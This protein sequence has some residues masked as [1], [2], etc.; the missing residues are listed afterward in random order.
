MKKLAIFLFLFAVRLTAVT[1]PA[2]PGVIYNYVD[3]TGANIP[4]RF[5]IDTNRAYNLTFPASVTGAQQNEVLSLSQF[6]NFGYSGVQPIVTVGP[7][8]PPSSLNGFIAADVAENANFAITTAQLGTMF[9]VT[10]AASTI[11]ATLPSAAAAGDGW[12]CFIRKVDTGAGLVVTSPTTTPAAT[13]VAIQDYV[14]LFWTD[15]TNWYTRPWKGTIDAAG[16]IAFK[17]TVGVGAYTTASNVDPG[18]ILYATRTTPPATL[19]VGLLDHHY[20][21]MTPVD[22]TTVQTAGLFDMQ[23]NGA[24]TIGAGHSIGFIARCTD[25]SSNV[26]AQFSGFE[27]KRQ[28]FGTSDNG[29]AI[30]SDTL[31]NMASATGRTAVGVFSTA[32]FFNG[33]PS[34]P[35]L[36]GGFTAFHAQ[37][38]GFGT[39]EGDSTKFFSLVGDANF[40]LQTGGLIASY[41][42]ATPL[43]STVATNYVGMFHNGTDGF[44]TVVGTGS[45]QLGAASTA[46]L[47]QTGDSLDPLTTGGSLGLSTNRWALTATTVA[48]NSSILSS[49]ATAGVGYTTGAGGAVTQLTSR[50]TGVTLNTVSGDITLF[51]AAGSATPATFTVTDSAIGAHDTVEVNEQS[52]TNLYETFV[53]AISAGSFNITFFTTGGTASDAPVFKFNVIKGS[54]N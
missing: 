51:T 49:S 40:K 48:A 54:A 3:T 34:A 9:Q 43:P 37:T 17:P 27:A 14:G 5:G 30:F 44:L 46:V 2:W 19:T 8:F 31:Y 25:T 41:S 29:A 7:L 24:D 22:N 26:S 42:G 35:I 23:L 1:V 11:T 20:Y 39:P 47:I 4:F 15:G 10:T 12:Y 50:T 28:A 18:C 36:T 16:N 32:E 6:N 21:A 33:N 13:S 52:G 38:P 53:T 45:L